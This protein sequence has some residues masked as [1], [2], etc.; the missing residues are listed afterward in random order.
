MRDLNN[1]LLSIIREHK[2]IDLFEDNGDEISDI[3]E[4][5]KIKFNYIKFLSKVNKGDMLILYIRDSSII[6]NYDELGKLLLTFEKGVIIIRKISSQDYITDSH[7]LIMSL[8]F[9]MHSQISNDN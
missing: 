5:N 6:N 7:N 1:I 8:G 4:K 2:D 9:M 3:L